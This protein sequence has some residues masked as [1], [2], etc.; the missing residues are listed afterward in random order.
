MSSATYIP[1]APRPSGSPIDCDVVFVVE[2]VVAGRPLSHARTRAC[3]TALLSGLSNLI[4]GSVRRFLY[5]CMWCHP[6]GPQTIR[7]LSDSFR[8]DIVDPTASAHRYLIH[9]RWCS[10]FHQ[11]ILPR[12]R[13][14]CPVR[15]ANRSI[16]IIRFVLYGLEKWMN[17]VTLASSH[18]MRSLT[19]ILVV[20]WSK[21]RS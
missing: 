6:N 2:S 3:P 21:E 14:N 16:K 10:M 13:H 9:C 5:Q 7:L 20:L 19:G 17:G 4:W 8:S 12:S 11:W 18:L 1:W 15:S